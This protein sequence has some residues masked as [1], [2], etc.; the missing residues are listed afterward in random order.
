[1]TTFWTSILNLTDSWQPRQNWGVII[2][3]WSWS[4]SFNKYSKY[5]EKTYFGTSIVNFKNSRVVNYNFVNLKNVEQKYV[6]P[7][8]KKLF[9]R[10]FFMSVCLNMSRLAFN[11]ATRQGAGLLIW[12]PRTPGSRSSSFV[13]SNLV[14][15]LWPHQPEEK[16]K[17]CCEWLV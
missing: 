13:M 12:Y 17:C 4:S 8:N 9:L 15:N 2:S 7:V 6:Y 10:S 16:L 14:L 11:S 3:T 5:L 1:M